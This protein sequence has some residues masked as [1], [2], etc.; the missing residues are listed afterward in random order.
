M[1]RPCEIPGVVLISHQ[2]RADA[3]GAF[4]KLFHPDDL[5]LGSGQAFAVRES[6]V[7]W[8]EPGV[9]RGMHFQSPPFAHDKAVTCLAGEVL[10]VVLD[11]RRSSPTYGRAAAFHLEGATPATVWIPAGCAHGFAVLGAGRAL[12][13]YAVTAEHS[14]AND[15]G[16]R[17]DSFGFAWPDGTAKVISERDRA[18]PPLADL[19]AVFA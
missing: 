15:L 6:F 12:L 11:L 4:T 7:S 5:G 1:A 9:L 8:S 16:V 3:R 2:V 10:D 18:L 13:H 19:P 17:W 14:P